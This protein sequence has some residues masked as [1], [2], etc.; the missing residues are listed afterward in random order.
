VIDMDKVMTEIKINGLERQ[1]ALLDRLADARE[2][3][4]PRMSR[5]SAHSYYESLDRIEQF[6]REAREL[7]MQAAQL[8]Q[9]SA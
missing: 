1:A 3:R 9:R 8:R 4:T 7:R 5:W 2:Q 6:R